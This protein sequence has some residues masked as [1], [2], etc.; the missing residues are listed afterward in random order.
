MKARPSLVGRAIRPTTGEIASRFPRY[1]CTL[2]DAPTPCSAFFSHVAV[3]SGYTVV[4]LP[5]ALRYGTRTLF[6]FQGTMEV[7]FVSC[8]KV[9]TPNHCH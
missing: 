4:F 5:V 1:F 8:R 2:I 9:E 3:V 6:S 7:F